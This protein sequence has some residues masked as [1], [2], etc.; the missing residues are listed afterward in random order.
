MKFTEYLEHILDIGLKYRK[1]V[2][3]PHF[4]FIECLGGDISPI[5]K[6]LDKLIEKPIEKFEIMDWQSIGYILSKVKN[7][8]KLDV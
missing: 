5:I 2:K 1:Y 3:T 6:D 8:G 7:R 4:F